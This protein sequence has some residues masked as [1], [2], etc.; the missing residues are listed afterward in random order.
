MGVSVF[1][2]PSAASRYERTVRI[3][4]T[5]S[6]TVPSDVS[7]LEVILCG[8]GG[9][10][11]W[12][13]NNNNTGGGGGGSVTYAV[14]AV[15][16]GSSHTVTI[17]AGGSANASGG[18]SSF[19]SLLS[20]TGGSPGGTYFGNVSGWG[21]AAAGLGGSGGSTGTA[22]SYSNGAYALS[23]N[24]GMPGAFGLGGGGGSSLGGNIV[25]ANGHSN[26]SGGSSGGGRGGFFDAN[27]STNIPAGSGVANSGSGGGGSY[28][29]QNAGSGG[30]GVCII[31]YW[32]AL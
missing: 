3:T 14:L 31:K 22:Q 8:G 25:S 32:S 17:G 13:P 27:T 7:Q 16:P 12:H 20:I 2:V 15:T 26:P 18:T 4:G 30:S 24:S 29:I 11:A 19:G 6:F 28:G 1:P 23:A 21:G 9:G 5:Q 10:G